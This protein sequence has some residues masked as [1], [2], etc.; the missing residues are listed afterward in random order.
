MLSK[1]ELHKAQRAWKPSL[2]TRPDLHRDESFRYTLHAGP[3]VTVNGV[4]PVIAFA[5][6]IRTHDFNEDGFFC[7]SVVSEEHTATFSW[8]GVVLE[9]PQEKFI[10]AASEDMRSTHAHELPLEQGLQR[11]GRFGLPSPE[12]VLSRASGGTGFFRSDFSW[13]EALVF[14]RAPARGRIRV[15]AFFAHKDSLG[16]PIHTPRRLKALQTAAKDMSVPFILLPPPKGNFVLKVR[17][18]GERKPV[19]AQFLTDYGPERIDFFAAEKSVRAV[20][21]QAKVRGEKVR[22]V[23][24]TGGPVD[25]LADET[26]FGGGWLER[27]KSSRPVSLPT[28]TPAIDLRFSQ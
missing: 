18:I 7:T 22:L 4:D 24:E 11:F 19:D 3:N 23:D 8:S 28:G 27:W 2:F 14:G 9:V 10:A 15:T 6:H 20:F 5:E 13:T 12:A 16:S 21:A 25:A 1:A 26:L 17:L